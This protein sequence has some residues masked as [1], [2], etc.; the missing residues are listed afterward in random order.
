MIFA[1]LPMNS[2]VF[3]DANI[4][5]FY[6][7]PHVVLGRSCTALIKRIELQELVGFTSTH[8]VSEVA[9]RLMTMEASIKLGWKSKIVNRLKQDPSAVQKLSDFRHACQQIPRLGFQ[10]LTI[11]R[12]L[13][14]TAA[15]ISQQYGLLT[16]DALTAAVMQANG[17]TNIASNDS[18]FDRVPG[19][20]R[21][22]PA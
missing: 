14:D 13:P 12:L 5:V 18:D 9:H 21:Y 19:L 15:G 6:F 2:T 20:T 11:D 22:A 1:D 4:F 8:V 3:V 10:L 7:Q 17:L 16:N